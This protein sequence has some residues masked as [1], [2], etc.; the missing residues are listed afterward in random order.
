M[1]VYKLSFTDSCVECWMFWDMFEGRDYLEKVVPVVCLRKMCHIQSHCF[2][3]FLSALFCVG[4]ATCFYHLCSDHN[5]SRT[6]NGV[7][8]KRLKSLKT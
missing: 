6:T 2:L 7:K 5:G 3:G 8:D 4:F 1:A